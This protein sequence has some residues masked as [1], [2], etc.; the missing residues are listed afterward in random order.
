MEV[1]IPSEALRAGIV[2]GSLVYVVSNAFGEVTGLFISNVGL[3]TSLL[4]GGIVTCTA[5]SVAGVI[6]SEAVK[7]LTDGVF[8]PIV[9][10]ST[11]LSSTG[12]AAGASLA[13]VAVVTLGIIGGRFV[14]NKIRPAQPID[15]VPIDYDSFDDEGFS[16]VHVHNVLGNP[17]GNPFDASAVQKN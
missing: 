14:L 11:Q 3:A 10:K 15:T 7:G 13:T 9:K 4:S 12:L 6:A 5:G 8:V 17:E 16:V 2:V 1:L